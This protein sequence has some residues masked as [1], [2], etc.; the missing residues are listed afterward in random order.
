MLHGHHNG[1]CAAGSTLYNC[2][3]HRDTALLMLWNMVTYD[4]EWHCTAIARSIALG[5]PLT[6]WDAAP[7]G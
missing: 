3:V 4:D 2:A 1:D 6:I 5:A 7:D